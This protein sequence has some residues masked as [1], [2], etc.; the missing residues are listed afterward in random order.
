MGHGE[1]IIIL[2]KFFLYDALIVGVLFF[3]DFFLD[4][5]QKMKINDGVGYFG[6]W[7]D[8]NTYK[9]IMIKDTKIIYNIFLKIFG[10]INIYNEEE[11]LRSM[12]VVYI[13]LF[14]FFSFS[15][16]YVINM[17]KLERV[18]PHLFASS[19]T[20]YFI[21]SIFFSYISM[22]VTMYFLEIMSNTDKIHIILFII[23]LD[24]IFALFVY[25][26]IVYS[27]YLVFGVIGVFPPGEF[28]YDNMFLAYALV[29]KFSIDFSYISLFMS[30]W[31]TLIHVL[32]T[33]SVV[34]SKAIRPIFQRPVSVFIDRLYQ[35]P[36]GVLATSAILLGGV[37]KF[38]QIVVKYLF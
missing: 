35:S 3:L 34:L 16:V 6:H 5:E 37:A 33:I 1:N 15:L 38:I 26:V 17:N 25:F 7:L 23:L 20:V 36:K 22:I 27:I 21:I 32:F 9:G 4:K 30:L 18:S 14:L 24:I 8:E 2:D 11:L 10:K 31:P 19:S 13:N 28:S 29:N 12:R